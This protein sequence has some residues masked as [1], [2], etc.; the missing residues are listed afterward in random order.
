[1]IKDYKNITD[2]VDPLITIK[3]VEGIKYDEL[4]DVKM[5]DG[6]VRRG[7][8]LEVQKDKAVVQLFEGSAGIDKMDTK[9]RFLGH[10]LTLDV[11]EDMIGR[12]FDGMGRIIDDGPELIAEKHYTFLHT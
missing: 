8:V 4:V 11:S 10:P 5:G 9:V 3:G 6:N 1:M 12:R 7:Q 2:I